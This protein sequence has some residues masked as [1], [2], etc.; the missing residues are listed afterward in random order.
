M[1]YSIPL[2]LWCVESKKLS[3]IFNRI[4]FCN[5]PN[6][7]AGISG[8]KGIRR[9]IS[10]YYTSCADH[11]AFSD[12][13]TSCNNYITGNPTVGT[14]CDWF[15]IFV[16][17]AGSVVFKFYIALLPAKW[18]HRSCNCTVRTE[19]HTVPNCY[20]AGIQYSKIESE[21]NRCA[22]ACQGCGAAFY[23]F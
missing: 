10:G 3:P 1:E 13:N 15:S 21:Q 6:H 22:M 16:I 20:R 14:Y 5:L 2:S 12:G 18:V 11:A 19:K 17:I 4:S 23:F 7:S 8:G 9:D